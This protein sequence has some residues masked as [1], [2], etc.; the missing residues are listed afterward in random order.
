MSDAGSLLFMAGGASGASG[1]HGSGDRS[2]QLHWLDAARGARVRR[3]HRGYDD[4]T[5]TLLIETVGLNSLTHVPTMEL[6]IKT[7][8][9]CQS[10]C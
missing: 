2:P 9:S 1:Q 5:V 7:L 3:P 4:N 8:F 10:S 6:N